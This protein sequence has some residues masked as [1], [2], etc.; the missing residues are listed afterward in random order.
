M[1]SQPAVWRLDSETST[2]LLAE[3]HAVPRLIWCGSRISDDVDLA[4]LQVHDDTALA[5]G[6]LDNVAPLTLFPQA[7]AAYT[8]SCALDG[9]RNGQQFAH[10][11]HTEKITQNGNSLHIYLSDKNAG[12]AIT[13][14]LTLDETSEVVS[15][16]T[17][18]CNPVSYTHLTLPTICSV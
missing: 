8:G 13:L 5:F 1:S 6:G 4:Q 16:S 18:L 7:S 2:L 17:R 15:L 14:E 12:L 10:A 11:L 9:H 3:D